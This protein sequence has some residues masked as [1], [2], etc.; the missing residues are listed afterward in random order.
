MDEYIINTIDWKVTQL[1]FLIR[2]LVAT[3][4][5]ILLGLEREHSAMIKSEQKFAG[6]RTFVFLTLLGFVG[7]ALHYLISP[8]ILAGVFFAVVTLTSVS[9]WFTAKQGDIGGTSELTGIMA[10]LLGCLVFMGYFE[11]SLVITVIALVFLSSKVQL[12]LVIGQITQEEMYAFV[13]FVVIALLIFPFLPDQNFGPYNAINPREVG[14]VIL[15]TSGLGFMGYVLMRVLGT[16]KGILL[17]GI[18]GGLVSSTLVT[19]I[20]AKK[21]KEHPTLA[22]VY[23]SGIL[24]ASTIM[25]LRVFLWVF[26]F[27]KFLIPGLSLSLGLMLLTAAGIT[28]YFF[29]KGRKDENKEASIPLG[30]PLDLGSAILFGGLYVLILIGIHFAND[31]IGPEGTLIT[32]GLAGLSDV[33]A[34]S[35][36]IAKLSTTSLPLNT[37]HQAILIATLA[38]TL[39]K[40]G[41]A[42]WAGH[43]VLRRFMLI[44]YGVIFVAALIGFGIL[45]F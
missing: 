7:T 24:A 21:S 28:V 15:L 5:G 16:G 39:M 3:G 33:D 38:N 20:F 2:L 37:A 10:V 25:V 11:I 29:L 23:A 14:L 9:Y 43:P 40:F 17:T 4:I 27:N 36:S 12:Q 22:T 30:K 6:I 31:W 45:L 42:V 35:I 41:I 18:V 8:W 19:W 13:R 32:S 26:L 1:D 44:G 34:I